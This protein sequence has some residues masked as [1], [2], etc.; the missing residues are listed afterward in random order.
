VS[1]VGFSIARWVNDQTMTYAD[2]GAAAFPLIDPQGERDALR[3][4]VGGFSE[5]SDHQVWA[6]GSWRVPVIYVADWPD[7]Y[8]HTTRDVPANIDPTKVKR[9]MFIAAASAWYLANLDE[10]KAKPLQEV[11]RAE[12]LQR[13]AEASRRVAAMRAAGA[14]ELDVANFVEQSGE[15]AWLLNRSIGRFGLPVDRALRWEVHRLPCIVDGCHVFRRMATP[16]GPMDGFG[17]SWL[18][19]HLKQAGIARPALLDRPSGRDGP[20]FGYETL[21]LVDGRRSVEEIR[22]ALAVTV[23]PAPLA[24]VVAYLSA[25][26]K[27]GVIERTNARD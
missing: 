5:G 20:S 10:S 3:A 14:P 26:E 1:D 24:E 17:Y 15:Y 13:Y 6:E 12:A 9:A 19:D 23:A 25:L 22:N 2:T 21:N 8:I 11:L 18:D 7:R 4:K 16:K 27:L